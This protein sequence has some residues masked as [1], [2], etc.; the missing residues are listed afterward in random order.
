MRFIRIKNIHCAAFMMLLTNMAFADAIQD[1]KDQAAIA[2][3]NATAQTALAQAEATLLKAQLN[4]A[5]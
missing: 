5:T 4:I 1:A 3:A 2:Q